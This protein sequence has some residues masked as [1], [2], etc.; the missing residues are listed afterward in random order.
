M[1]FFFITP[2]PRPLPQGE[3]EFLFGAESAEDAEDKKGIMEYW[4][5]GILGE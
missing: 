4:N 1:I 3:R 2:H 5:H